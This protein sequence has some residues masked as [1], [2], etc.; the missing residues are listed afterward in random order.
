METV[1]KK[2]YRYFIYSKSQHQ[3]RVE[4]DKKI[5]KVFKPGKVFYNGRWIVYTSI[6]STPVT[7]F[8]DGKVVA[9][10]YLEDMKYLSHSS[11]WGGL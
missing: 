5:N 3:L 4:V 6:S 10:G 9:E 1:N 2:R 7:T 11:V 8:P